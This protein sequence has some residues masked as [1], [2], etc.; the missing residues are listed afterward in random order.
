MSNLRNEIFPI[1]PIEPISLT[2]KFN[3]TPLISCPLLSIIQPNSQDD[4]DMSSISPK[5]EINACGL[6]LSRATEDKMR[7]KMI[8]I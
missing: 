4:E 2:I 5:L 7:C 8:G 1:E 6:W 3:K